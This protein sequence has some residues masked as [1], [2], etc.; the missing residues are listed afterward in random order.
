MYLT[1]G[2]I[3][4][5]TEIPVRTTQNGLKALQKLHEMGAKNVII[6][7]TELQD[8]DPERL[9]LLASIAKD[10]DNSE[11]MKPFM[12]DFPKRTQAFTGTGDL[13]AALVL[14]YLG[15]REPVRDIVKEVTEKAT[16]VM[17]AVLE[18]TL[19]VAPL[20]LERYASMKSDVA[21]E[22]KALELCIIQCKSVIEN[23]FPES[24]RASDIVS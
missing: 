16:S 3:R 10:K 21:R 5:L 14:G 1:L 9:Y 8:K 2:N 22:R 4:I 24:Y 15:A 13:F 18:E 20:R 23:P 19:R 11:S 7:S 17:Q 12:I 6:T